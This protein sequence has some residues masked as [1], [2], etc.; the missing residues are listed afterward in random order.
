[1]ADTA[2]WDYMRI[3]LKGRLNWHDIAQ[4]GGQIIILLALSGFIWH[5]IYSIFIYCDLFY[6]LC[7]GNNKYK[8]KINNKHGKYRVLN[9]KD[10]FSSR[11]SL[12]TYLCI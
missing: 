8:L 2:A 12:K 7:V 1:M 5:S 11:I 3:L 6:R 9:P 10:S 4:T